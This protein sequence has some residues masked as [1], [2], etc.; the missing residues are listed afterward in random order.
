M[1]LEIQLNIPNGQ[2]VNGN[3]SIELADDLRSE[4]EFFLESTHVDKQLFEKT[5]TPKNVQG[6]FELVQWV[7]ENIEE[8]DKA[9][10]MLSPFIIKLSSWAYNKL[11]VSK[12]IKADEKPQI[13]VII[14]NKK[15]TLPKEK[16][17]LT[18][19]IKQLPNQD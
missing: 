9:I 2:E 5:E 10:R 15:I 6:A 18:E 13:L 8:H 3:S 12:K 4:I 7:L 14:D 16:E 11:F 19:Y 17:K 1:K